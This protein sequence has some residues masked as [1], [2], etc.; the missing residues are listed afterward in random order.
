LDEI[1]VLVIVAAEQRARSTP[2]LFV[3]SNAVEKE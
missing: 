3:G 1:D 2:L